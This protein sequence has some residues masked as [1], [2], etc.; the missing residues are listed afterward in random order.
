MPAPPVVAQAS[1]DSSIL[2]LTA[3]ARLTR[4]ETE[5]GETLA[6]DQQTR[7]ANL[8]ATVQSIVRRYHT[9]SKEYAESEQ[10]V[11]QNIVTRM[12]ATQS[13]FEVSGIVYPEYEA[14]ITLY[15]QKADALKAATELHNTLLNDAISMDC[16]SNPRGFKALI[17]AARASR[18]E[19]IAQRTA[20]RQH[21]EEVIIPLTQQISTYTEDNS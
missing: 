8:C 15:A 13:L 2:Q 10:I 14:A 3:E 19:M 6:A 18:P 1:P 17:T 7:L 5:Y 20:L 16:A 12:G 21:I 4:I 11:H 9:G